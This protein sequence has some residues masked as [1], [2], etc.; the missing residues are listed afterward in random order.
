MREQTTV[1]EESDIKFITDSRGN[2]KEVVISYEKFKELMQMI[3]D[4][5]FLHSPEIQ[6][7]I[8]QSEEDIKAGRYVRAKGSEI[9]KLLEW[10]NEGEEWGKDENKVLLRH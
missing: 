10:L 7:Q 2:R 4:H 6:E 3:E 5:I 9:D 1:L 8:R